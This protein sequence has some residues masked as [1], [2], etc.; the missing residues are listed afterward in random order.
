MELTTIKPVTGI[1]TKPLKDAIVICT[2]Y[3][4][5]IRTTHDKKR[6]NEMVRLINNEI[7]KVNAKA[8]GIKLVTNLNDGICGQVIELFCHPSNS[9]VYEV[10]KQTRRD[11][12]LKNNG[13]SSIQCEVKINGGRVG[14]LLDIPYKQAEKMAMVYFIN[15]KNPTKGRPMRRA[16]KIFKLSDFLDYV[17]INPKCITPIKGAKNCIQ[18]KDG[19]G[20]QVTN[21]SW[22]EDFILSQRDFIRNKDFCF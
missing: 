6:Y 12:T 3:K 9:R 5:T 15:I 17:A 22:F 4:T 10:R 13:N 16:F 2:W 8:K 14:D 11:L 1:L 18:S 21:K 20:I 7:D 19:L